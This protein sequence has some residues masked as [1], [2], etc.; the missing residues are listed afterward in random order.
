MK[1][2]NISS[3]QLLSD[4]KSFKIG[5]FDHF[6][7]LAYF[8]DL[9]IV[10]QKIFYERVFFRS[11]KKYPVV[12]TN[13]K[14]CNTAEILYYFSNQSKQIYTFDLTFDNKIIYHCEF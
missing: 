5:S 9:N 7:M 2:Y 10:K 11:T 1:C 4:Y 6:W 12:K 13:K 8:R 3:I 14:F